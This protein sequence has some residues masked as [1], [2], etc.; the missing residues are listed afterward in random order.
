[1]EE[2][3]EYYY[4]DGLRLITIGQLDQA[5]EFFTKAI[6]ID[7][8]FSDAYHNRGHI[9][10]MTD[11]IIKGNA[12]IKKAK[13]LRS[14]KFKVKTNGK[15]KK[16][17]N[18][19][20][21]K[22][23]WQEVDCIYD[24]VFPVGC[25][26][27]ENVM[28]GRLDWQEV[29]SIY[30]SVFPFDSQDDE[31][32]ML[33]KLNWQQVD[34]IYDSVISFDSQDDE[35]DTLEVDD[36][37]DYQTF[38]DDNPETQKLFK[39]HFKPAPELLYHPAILEFLNGRCLE[40]SRVILFKPTHN[41]ISI[42][43]DDGYIERVVKLQH[44]TCIRTQELPPELARNINSSC[45]VERVETVNGKNYLVAVHPEQKND[46]VLFG[47]SSKKEND[48][49]FTFIP[50]ANIRN[51]YLDRFFGEILKEKGFIGDNLL[52]HALEEHQKAKTLELGKIIALKTEIPLSI[53]EKKLKQAKQ[54][55]GLK[56]LKTGEILLASGIVN[57]EQVLD[58]LHYQEYLRKVKIGQY[59]ID[60]GIVREKEVYSALAEKFRVPFVDLREVKISRN[61][62]TI[63]PQNFVL[64]NEILPLSLDNGILSVAMLNPDILCMRD[65]I[66][67]ECN[68]RE[69]RF[70]LALPSHLKLVIDM[71]YSENEKN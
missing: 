42:I 45:Q 13:D 24:T 7:P 60:R 50:T 41:D 40:A 29:D 9:F 2:K 20:P 16:I 38:R 34:S 3:A 18:A 63:L 59:L 68:C 11:R 8:Q 53:I 65:E 69:V 64:Q 66:M 71:L 6:E 36:H 43:R 47:F 4:K 31:N 52:K 1:M 26:E 19:K 62:L 37:F 39:D 44:L 54:Q 10:L 57:E 14:G 55:E 51:R 61:I 17:S 27:A 56:E 5:V 22:M 15:P 67:K 48:F 25:R 21:C 35:I 46:N 49:T 28:T 58:A 30:D 23:N 33:D 12:D 70:S 32:E